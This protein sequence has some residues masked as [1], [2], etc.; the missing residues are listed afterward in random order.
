MSFYILISLFL[1][2]R[3]RSAKILLCMAVLCMQQFSVFME[4][5]NLHPISPEVKKMK[6]EHFNKVN[7]LKKKTLDNSFGYAPLTTNEEKKIQEIIGE[8]VKG[9]LVAKEKSVFKEVLLLKQLAVENGMQNPDKFLRVHETGILEG[10][11][12]SDLYLLLESLPKGADCHV[13]STFMGNLDTLVNIA[14]K[15]FC[16][17]DYGNVYVL[18]NPNN[19]L[20]IKGFEVS[21]KIPPNPKDGQ[22]SKLKDVVGQHTETTFLEN[23]KKRLTLKNKSFKHIGE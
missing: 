13:H 10:D 19:Q 17:G 5:P 7:E 11:K 8:T 9:D 14:S 6:D 23:L 3:M 12:K 22:Y 2:D 20:D 16:G 4:F 1:F 15:V 18:H 21:N